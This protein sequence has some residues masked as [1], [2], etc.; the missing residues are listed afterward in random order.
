M[1]WVVVKCGSVERGE[2]NAGKEKMGWENGVG[3][4]SVNPHLGPIRFVYFYR[5]IYL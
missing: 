2:T 3:A 1:W 5:C 4:T